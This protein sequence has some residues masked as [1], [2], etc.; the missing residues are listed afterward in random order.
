MVLLFWQEGQTLMEI[1]TAGGQPLWMSHALSRLP[2][3]PHILFKVRLSL[4]AY[5]GKIHERFTEEGA[6]CW[7][8]YFAGCLIPS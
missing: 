7:I 2:V 8:I 1:K 6:V 4:S 5:D 3:I